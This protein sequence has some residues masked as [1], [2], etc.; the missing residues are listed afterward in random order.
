MSSDN[1]V[2]PDCPSSTKIMKEG[3]RAVSEIP[4]GESRED[5]SYR[6]GRDERDDGNHDSTPNRKKSVSSQQAAAGAQRK[7]KKAQAEGQHQ[8]QHQQQLPGRFYP[9][10]QPPHGHFPMGSGMPQG[11]GPY[12]G[13]P[14]LYAGGNGHY[15]PPPYHPHFHSQMPPM[16][17]FNGGGPY[18][19]HG[20]GNHQRN[21]GNGGASNGPYSS[22]YGNHSHPY[23]SNM[24][25]NSFGSHGMPPSYP[26][27]STSD[28]ASMSSK[29][30][31][32]SKKRTIDGVHDTQ[33]PIPPTSAPHVYTFRRTDSNSSTTSTVT[34]GNNTSIETHGTEESHSRHENHHHTRTGDALG[35]PGGYDDHDSYHNEGRPMR[36]RYHRRD[37]SADASTTSSL[38]AGFSLESYEGPRGTNDKTTNRRCFLFS[39]D[40]HM[41]STLRTNRSHGNRCTHSKV[42]S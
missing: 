9:G 35:P 23:N 22:H 41:N 8:Q 34:A 13:P 19:A 3:L 14:Y 25:P 12:G 4:G 36:T 7:G 29:G 21:T 18:P 15:P 16:P 32:S 6:D 39:T 37:Y 24:G 20:M 40:S 26:N 10:R 28:S 30:S 27:M 17:H 5:V 33:P 31:K 42:V 2:Q 1:I 11:P 38:S